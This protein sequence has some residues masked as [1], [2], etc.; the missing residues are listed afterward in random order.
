MLRLECPMEAL[1]LWDL[2]ETSFPRRVLTAVHLH[3]QRGASLVKVNPVYDHPKSNDMIL[4]CK[5]VPALG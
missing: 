1:F 5:T 3:Q 4:F 2:N